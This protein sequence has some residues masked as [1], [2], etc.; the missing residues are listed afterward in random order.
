MGGRIGLTI[1]ARQPEGLVGMAL[2]DPPLSGPGR[3]VYGMDLAWYIDSIRLSSKGCDAE[4]MRSFLPRW[5][6]EALQLRAEWL[7]TCDERAVTDSFHFLRSED[8]I[9]SASKIAVPTLLMIA[10]GVDV[11]RPEE[12]EE[13][14]SLI[15]DIAV[16]TVP[17]AGHMI[18]WENSE[19]F[20]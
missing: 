17:E 10:G 9:G 16:T 18:P 1:G 14:V 20:F 4:A 6:D 15:P 11:I 7:H 19:G 12:A 3:R 2:I 8:V 13:L 5:S